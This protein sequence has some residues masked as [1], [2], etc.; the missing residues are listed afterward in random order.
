MKSRIPVTAVSAVIVLTCAPVDSIASRIPTRSL[1]AVP[2]GYVGES[3][4]WVPDNRQPARMLQAPSITSAVA[5]D[6]AGT[7]AQPAATRR[8]W[9]VHLLHLLRFLFLGGILR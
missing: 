4:P 2:S 8:A 1:E 5:P 7:P 9:H 3:D 6:A